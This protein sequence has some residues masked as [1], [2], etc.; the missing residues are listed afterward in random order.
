MFGYLDSDT[1]YHFGR[2]GLTWGIDRY[3]LRKP[4]VFGVF[5]HTGKGTDSKNLAHS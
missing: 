1:I 4:G 5:G 3:D 2:N